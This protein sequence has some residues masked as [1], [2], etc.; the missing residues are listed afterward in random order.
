MSP[1]F[2]ISQRIENLANRFWPIAGIY[3]RLIYKKKLEKELSMAKLKPGSSVL[4][5]GCGPCPYTAI[6]LAKQGLTVK[7]LD[8]NTNAVQKAKELVKKNN[9]EDSITIDC[10]DG[11]YSKIAEYDAIWVSLNVS[12][13]EQ[14]LEQNF[15]SLKDSGILIYRNVTRWLSSYFIS[16]LPEKWPDP[17]YKE[18]RTS[19]MGAESVMVKKMFM[20]KPINCN[21]NKMINYKLFIQKY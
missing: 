12:P 9:L 20:I 18:T 10:K 11:K 7:A 3:F 14:V 1:Y 17:H 19:L 8:Y 16:V 5:I 2:N 15:L 6:Y 13:K 21:I 4:H